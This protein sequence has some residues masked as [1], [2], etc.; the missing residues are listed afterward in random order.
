MSLLIDVVGVDADV[1][2]LVIDVD[3]NIVDAVVVH[4]VVDMTLKKYSLDIL[5]DG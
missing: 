4:I 5:T 2:V 1:I 3:V